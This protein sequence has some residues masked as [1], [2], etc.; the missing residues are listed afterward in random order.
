MNREK[1]E[2]LAREA[3]KKLATYHTLKN[4][5]E[6]IYSYLLN[7]YGLDMLGAGRRETEQFISEKL[8]Q[9]PIPILVTRNIPEI[10]IGDDLL[11]YHWQVLDREDDEF[12][13]DRALAAALEYY[14]K[15][16][17]QHQ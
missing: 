1:R 15:S 14:Q 12:T 2:Q 7:T 16:Q 11:A 3:A 8:A 17:E 4:P 9:L 10:S 5:E 6:A 13:F